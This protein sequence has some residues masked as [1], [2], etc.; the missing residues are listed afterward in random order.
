MI[1]VLLLTHNGL[2]LTKEAVHSVRRQDVA[3][4]LIVIDNASTDGTREWLHT[5]D[6]ETTTVIAL[7]SNVGVSK[8]WNFGLRWLLDQCR[9][10][11][12]LVINNDVVLRPDTARTLWEDGAWFVTAVGVNSLA[13]SQGAWKKSDRPNPDFSCFLI[14]RCAWMKVGEFDERFFAWHGD[15]DY[16]V[17]LTKAGVWA[18]TCGI[19]YYHYAA[20]TVKAAEGDKEAQARWRDMFERDRAAFVAKW[21]V[22]PGTKEYERMTTI[23]GVESAAVL[24]PS[25]APQ[26][27]ADAAE[28]AG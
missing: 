17:R 7:R 19:P 8:A 4:H 6:A 1:P 20:A 14:S 9:M 16:H 26:P 27:P 12:V 10:A 11:A 3:T 28:P 2:A 13:E 24:P 21:G 23:T 18:G 22:A 15:N 5:L 25:P